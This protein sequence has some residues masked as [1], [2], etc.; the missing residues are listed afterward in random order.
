MKYQVKC[1]LYIFLSIVIV[2]LIILYLLIHTFVV[3]S[4]L[5]FP[6]FGKNES[7]SL[8]NQEKNSIDNRLAKAVNINNHETKSTQEKMVL[9]LKDFSI[10]I[11]SLVKKDKKVFAAH[12]QNQFNFDRDLLDVKPQLA[13]DQLDLENTQIEDQ[14]RKIIQQKILKTL[15]K[16][17][18]RMSVA[19]EKLSHHVQLETA[20]AKQEAP[21]V[22]QPLLEQD[23]L[24]ETAQIKQESPLVEQPLLEQ[25]VLLETAQIKQEAPLVKQPLLEQNVLSETAQIKQE[26]P[27]VKQP[28]LEQD[29]LLEKTQV[30]QLSNLVQL[31]SLDNIDNKNILP[32]EAM[33]NKSLDL[34]IMKAALTP[35]AILEDI[36]MGYQIQNE[37]EQEELSVCN[38]ND[39]EIDQILFA[40]EKREALQDT[41]SINSDIGENSKGIKIL[42]DDHKYL[43]STSSVKKIY[44][45]QAEDRNMDLKKVV[46]TYQQVSELYR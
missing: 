39:T 5:N 44:S 1:K 4:I 25:D 23:V 32:L 7:N 41:L 14:Q 43:I 19:Q 37:L 24:L 29:V 35:E 2:V 31:P 27:L 11:D 33:T 10:T 3:K 28:L 15:A 12:S 17:D 45:M 13:K 8:L 42:V 16:E 46:S 26:A 38:Q 18:E 6:T 9:K 36:Q 21:S 22:K 30:Q 20:Q 40:S 34:M